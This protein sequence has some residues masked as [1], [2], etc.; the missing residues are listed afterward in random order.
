MGELPWLLHGLP[1]LFPRGVP[2]SY[3][4]GSDCQERG[5]RAYEKPSVWVARW[6]TS[7]RPTQAPTIGWTSW[8]MT[9]KNLARSVTRT[10]TT[11]R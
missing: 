5:G 11:R 8:A 9:S 2:K 7:P 3:A 6:P 10:S 4:R 1:G